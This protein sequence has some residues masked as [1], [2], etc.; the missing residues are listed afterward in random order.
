VR[1]KWGKVSIAECL[2]LSDMKRKQSHGVTRQSE[3]A[4]AGLGIELST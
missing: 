1:G 3:K 4:P 2:I